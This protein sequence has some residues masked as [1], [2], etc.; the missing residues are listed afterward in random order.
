VAYN[1][2]A[3]RAEYVLWD[4]TNARN[5]LYFYKPTA[6]ALRELEAVRLDLKMIAD[7]SAVE[8]HELSFDID[9]FT[10]GI[11]IILR[12]SDLNDGYRKLPGFSEDG[13]ALAEFA[14]DVLPAIKPG[15][16]SADAQALL[17][18]LEDISD[19]LDRISA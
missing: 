5:P 12:P 19:T 16:S 3:I 4:S 17:P 6:Q 7:G 10:S 8:P 1:W 9:V 18:K 2:S 11:D 13:A 15:L 14:A